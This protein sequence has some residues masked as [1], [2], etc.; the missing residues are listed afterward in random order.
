MNKE[1]IINALPFTEPFLFVD[2]I[3][4][5]NEKGVQGSYT[6]RKNS[7]FYAGHFKDNPVTP[8]VILTEVMAQIGVVCMG[9]FLLGKKEVEIRPKIALT[10]N[11]IDFYLPVYPGEKVIVESEKIYFRFN[12]LKCSVRMLNEKKELVCR[13]EI[14]GMIVGE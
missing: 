8:G 1:E 2:E 7:F 5:I 10:S 6:F 14:A 11:Q 4:T 3:M 12:K 13:G 9:I